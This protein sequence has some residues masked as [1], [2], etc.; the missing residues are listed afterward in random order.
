M[1]ETLILRFENRNSAFVN[2]LTSI[3]NEMNARGLLKSGA[4]IKKGHRALVDELVGSRL[5]LVN[6]F[7]D[8]LF[9]EKPAKVNQVLIQSSV[10]HLKERKITIEG[11]YT[12]NMRVVTDSLNNQSMLAPYISLDEVFPLNLKE[13]KIDIERASADYLSSKGNTLYERVRN[14]FLD[15]PMIVIAL[16][17]MTAVSTLLIFLKLIGIFDK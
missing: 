8:Y 1:D 3:K 7:K 5:T 13:L 9:L 15:K 10:K 16:I 11:I 14:Q 2:S 6:T 4:A 12:Q 17:T